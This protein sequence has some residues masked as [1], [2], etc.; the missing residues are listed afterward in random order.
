MLLN[1]IWLIGPL[2]YFFAT[3]DSESYCLCFG[4]WVLVPLQ[5]AAARC[6]AFV[7][8]RACVLVLLGAAQACY[9]NMS[10]TVC[11]RGRC[12]VLLQCAAHKI[13]GDLGSTL[14]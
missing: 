13:F 12:R 9:C 1:F 7:R 14:A 8:F 10:L 11:A 2:F 3:P 5:G 6:V 4:A